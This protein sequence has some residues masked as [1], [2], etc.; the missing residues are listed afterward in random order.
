MI[1]WQVAEWRGFLS[2]SQHLFRHCKLP[3]LSAG[4]PSHLH[5]DRSIQPHTSN[6]ALT[7]EFVQR[8]SIGV[9]TNI[10]AAVSEENTKKSI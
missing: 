6:A 9:A 4:K 5:A 7:T 3:S 10:A 8:N 2:T 1:N